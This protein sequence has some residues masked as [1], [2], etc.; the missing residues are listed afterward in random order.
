MLQSLAI[1]RSTHLF[2]TGCPYGADVFVEPK[3][4]FLERQLAV[5]E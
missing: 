4:G 1:D 3:A 2:G 5:I